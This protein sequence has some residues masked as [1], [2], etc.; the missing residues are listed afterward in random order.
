MSIKDWASY[1]A[2]LDSAKQN[3]AWVLGAGVSMERPRFSAALMRANNI[4]LPG[5]VRSLL[6]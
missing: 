6:V 5:Y 3:P 4:A 1:A 2:F